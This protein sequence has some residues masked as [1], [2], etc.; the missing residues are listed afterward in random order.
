LYPDLLDSS[1]AEKFYWCS[2][3]NYR[4]AVPTHFVTKKKVITEFVAAL[5]VCDGKTGAPDDISQQPR[6]AS[7]I[8]SN[9]LAV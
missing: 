7:G 2:V 5:Q 1:T 4:L 9:S 6:E 3:Q 8:A